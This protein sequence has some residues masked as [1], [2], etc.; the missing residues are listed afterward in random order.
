MARPNKPTAL[1][2]LNGAFK[3]DPAR[4]RARE[5]EPKPSGPLGEPPA[6]FPPNQKQAWLEL[7]SQAPP[8]VLTNVAAITAD[9][10]ISPGNRT[11]KKP[12]VRRNQ[13]SISVS[14]GSRKNVRVNQMHPQTRSALPLARL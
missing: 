3:K 11:A 10:T 5:H 6:S 13:P 1:L 14:A 2:E 7:S 4:R 12:S 8:G 9:M